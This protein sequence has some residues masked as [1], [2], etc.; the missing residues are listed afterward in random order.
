[1][2]D[3]L[4]LSHRVEFYLAFKRREELKHATVWRSLTD[5]MPRATN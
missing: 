3:R 2:V 1:M 4:W 5:V